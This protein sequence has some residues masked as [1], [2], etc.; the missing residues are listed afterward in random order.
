MLRQRLLTAAVQQAFDRRRLFTAVLRKKCFALSEALRSLVDTLQT[1]T[2]R[3][4]FLVTLAYFRATRSFFARQR[5]HEPDVRYATHLLGIAL[6][7]HCGRGRR[8]RRSGGR[9][10]Y[11]RAPSGQGAGQPG[12]IEQRK[13]PLV[14]FGGA[15]LS[16]KSFDYQIR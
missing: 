7:R 8:Q 5:M 11:E 14:F 10:R 12:G 13:A 15:V 6:G 4:C 3:V 2:K 9:L 1:P 16:L